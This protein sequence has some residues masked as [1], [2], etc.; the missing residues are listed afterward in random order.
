MGNYLG[1]STE[2]SNYSSFNASANNI[3]NTDQYKT[4]MFSAFVKKFNKC[5]KSADR[6]VLVT[7]A[8][9]YKLDG[10]KN[11]FKNMKR[12]IAIKEIT[13]ISVSPGRDQLVVFHSHHNNDLI[14]NLQGEHTQLK[15]DRVGEIIGHVCKKY[16][17]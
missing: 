17:E 13:G 1:M 12:S 16:F 4:I 3:K 9:V 15:E 10:T 6:S 8:A 11:K 5:N 2:N 14:I 7:D